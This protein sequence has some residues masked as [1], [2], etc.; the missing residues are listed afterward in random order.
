M[1]EKTYGVTIIIPVY[2]TEKYLM[3]CINSV[4]N[5][6]YKNYEII[7]VNDGSTDSSRNIIKNY[8]NEHSN[9]ILLEQE[10]EGQ[11]SARNK[12]INEAKGKYIYFLDSDDYILPTTI[13]RLYNTCEENELDLILFDGDSFYDED[14]DENIKIDKRYHRNEV[15]DEV[16]SGEVLLEKL[17][18]N[19]DFFVSPCLYM[20]SKKTLETH[21]IFFPEGIIH[22]DELFTFELFKYSKKVKHLNEVLFMRRL[23]KNSTMTSI[24]AIRSFRG[25]AFIFYEFY[26]QYNRAL[27]DFATKKR[28]GNLY[29][30]VIINYNLL[31][32]KDKIE[33]KNEIKAIKKIGVK[34]KYFGKRLGYII[35]HTFKIYKVLSNF[36]RKLI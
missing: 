8:L 12:A 26:K 5:Q 6:T 23:R 4:L 22:E 29:V 20:L 24:D 27:P 31:D 15:Y 1:V 17:I 7:I 25:Y 11:G 2:N 9:M 18:E 32:S 30:K 16:Y 33:N 19:N 34:N 10:N 35:T 21:N 28:L 13:E 3:E 14:I 36:K